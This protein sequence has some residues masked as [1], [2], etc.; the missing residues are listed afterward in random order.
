MKMDLIKY[1]DNNRIFQNKN[2]FYTFLNM[3]NYVKSDMTPWILMYYNEVDNLGNTV[4]SVD[5]LCDRN[6]D[7]KRLGININGQNKIFFLDNDK[8]DDDTFG[9]LAKY[10]LNC[11]NEE[12]FCLENEKRH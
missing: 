2:K 1:N 4:K 8:I 7:Y 6:G 5:A 11:T 10:F 9:M 3:S 12:K